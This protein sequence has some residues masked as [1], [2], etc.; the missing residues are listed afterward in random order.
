MD[1]KKCIFTALVLLL[2]AGITSLYGIQDAR[3]LRN[4]D[5]NGNKIVF[6]YGGDLWATT[7]GGGNASRLT[8][9]P[10]QEYNPYFSPDGKWIAFS[11]E[12]DGN[13]DVFI[14]PAEGGNPKRLTYHPMPDEVTGWSAD[15]KYVYFSTIRASHNRY[16]RVFKISADGG[17][18]DPLPMPMAYLG[19][20]SADGKYFAYTKL[21]N[22]QSFNWWRRYRGGHAPFIWIFNNA[23]LSVKMIPHP[24][25]NDSFPRWMGKDVYFLSDRDR[26]M[27]LYAF[28]Q[29][30][31]KLDKL[32]SF[33][34]A[35]I[36]SF[37]AAGGKVVF[38]REGYLHL[39]DPGTKAVKK[40][41]V[42][43][44]G[45]LMSIRPGFKKAGRLI[46]NYSISP[47]GKRVAFGA[48]G[49]IVTVPADKGDIRNL[50]RTTDNAE[51]SPAW[52]PDGKKI[53]YFG[54]HNKKYALFIVDQKG[55][56]KPKIFEFD[57]SEYYND[58]EWSPDSKKVIFENQFATLYYLDTTSPN[59]KPVTVADE[60]GI[61]VPIDAA[62]S[63]DS[64]WIAYT[65]TGKNKLRAVHF[66]SL[67]TGKSSRVTDGMS[68]INSLSFDPE[69][70]YLYF[71]ASTNW[72]F[73]VSWVDMTAINHQVVR[74]LYLVVLSAKE[75]SP[76]KPESDEEEEKKDGDKKKDNGKD[77][78]KKD[79]KGKDK[80]AETKKETKIDF[81][82]IGQ[83]IVA[84]PVPTRQYFNL[85]AAKGKLFFEELITST[86]SFSINLHAF[87]MKKRKD[88]T[89]IKD[90][91]DYQLSVD[92]KK[93]AL[94]KRGFQWAVVDSSGKGKPGKG[95]LKTGR[96]EVYSEPLKEWRQILYDAWRIQR[97]FFYDPG[98]HGQ[99]W[100]A[101]WKQ[102]E[103]YL[104]YMAH[105]SD[106]SY[107][108]GML[109][110]E[111]TVGH[112]YVF[113]GE[114]PQ[115]D[116]VGGG[117]LG[118]DYEVKDGFYRIKKIYAG[119]NWNPNMRSPLTEPAILV[120]EG[121]FLLEVDGRTVKGTD[122]IYSFFEKTS[123]KQVAIKVNDKPQMAGARTYTV[124]PIGGEY[125][126]R[127]RDWIETN[128]KIVAKLS[129]GKVGYVYLPNT[130]GAGFTSFN[131]YYY[132]HLDKEAMVLDERFNGGGMA[133]DYMVDMMDRPLMNWWVG[134][135]GREGRT[136]GAANDGPKVMIID[137]YAGS[138]GDALPYYFRFRKLGKLVGKRTWG[139]LVGI[140]GYP[141]LMDGGMV[142]SPTTS[143][144]D[145][146]GNFSVE[147]E[148]VPP[149]IEVE[150][151]PKLM[152]KGH[153]PQLEAAVKVVL[154]E[155][156]KKKPKKFK[157]N[158]F[159][160]GR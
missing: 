156:K 154:E 103:R 14:I 94:M 86:G 150:Q 77:K 25:S 67:K 155:L 104:P 12:Y 105:R 152:I 32:T 29:K 127:I 74:N 57:K 92:G 70:K 2:T 147:N 102:Y 133:A 97:E 15:G 73:N 124:V 140:T 27:N 87:D 11:G 13:V 71:A 88:E 149:D 16:L 20:E 148:G 63:P 79:K 7:T 106:L 53:A 61:T 8:S 95:A 52:S 31:N 42:N 43:I 6:S 141:R 109:I 93:V 110:G 22:R 37:G 99:D 132:A 144:V 60:P 128:R 69:G 131:R 108:I 116:R 40:L 5:I 68:D 130:A 121:D 125:F 96:I 85:Q 159:P 98:M 84:I 19:S 3:L 41:T 36:K 120:K 115:L 118:A 10:G 80:K 33:K 100:P 146:D 62:W 72:A 75:P 157:H 23:D 35:D 21:S 48:R 137:E 145:V 153:D 122:N 113:G 64:N 66:Y 151:T 112:A 46:Y 90:I 51:R 38:E 47:T 65:Q 58:L 26:V 119:E 83:R 114:Y 160:R 89:V 1:V 78:D 45:D 101:I 134:R 139:G 28:D 50:T 158:G 117:L 56:S 54:E 39:L 55:L 142:T 4:P 18:P 82:G 138:G 30:T 111:L 9:H 136:P 123:G 49:E 81:Q 76:F 91:L 44:P 143:F 34:G 129:G 135:W 59:A 17:F 107:V 126:L 24:K